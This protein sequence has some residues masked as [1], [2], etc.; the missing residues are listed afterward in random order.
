MD[1]NVGP[2]VPN[3]YIMS[4]PLRPAG[5]KEALQA[6]LSSGILQVFALSF[7]VFFPFMIRRVQSNLFYSISDFVDIL[8]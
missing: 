8:P 2:Y 7:F 3:R 5:H 6:A 1:S 4:P